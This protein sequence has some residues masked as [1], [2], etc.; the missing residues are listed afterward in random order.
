MKKGNKNGREGQSEEEK[1]RSL[2]RLVD[3]TETASN[4]T[5]C[6]QGQ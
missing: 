1:N 4:Q 3:F 6:L 5:N 2:T